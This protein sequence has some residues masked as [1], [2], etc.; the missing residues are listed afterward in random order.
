MA[1][2]FPH[3]EYFSIG[4]KIGEK[5][6]PKTKKRKRERERDKKHKLPI[7]TTDLAD[8]MITFN[9]LLLWQTVITQAKNLLKHFF[10]LTFFKQN[11][12]QMIFV[13]EH[14]KSGK[15]N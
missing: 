15:S 11:F 2:Y 9:Y 4:L 6:I 8:A 10:R 3:Q 13:T 14:C 5:K 1:T 12:K 7:C